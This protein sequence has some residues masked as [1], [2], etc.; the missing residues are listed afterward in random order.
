M[1]SA[2]VDYDDTAV[3]VYLDDLLDE[4]GMTREQLLAAYPGLD[5]DHRG[6]DGE[7]LVDRRQIDDRD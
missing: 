5:V 6:L 1:R 3:W 2:A 7:H 4:L